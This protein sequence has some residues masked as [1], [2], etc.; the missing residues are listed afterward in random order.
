MEVYFYD[1]ETMIY[2]GHHQPARL[3]PIDKL[4]MIPA[5]STTAT[6]P[7]PM[8]G[9]AARLEANE[10]GEMEWSLRAWQ[11]FTIY[12]WDAKTTELSGT[13]I[14]TALE[15]PEVDTLGENQTFTAPPGPVPPLRYT[16]YLY[17]GIWWQQVEDYRGWWADTA[18]AEKHSIEDF[19]EI[20][21]AGWTD[22]QIPPGLK[23][24]LWDGEGWV[25]D[26]TK[27]AEEEEAR[28]EAAQSILKGVTLPQAKAWIDTNVTDLASAKVALKKMLALQWAVM[29]IAGLI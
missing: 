7:A 4:P 2:T 8:E 17:G 18:T 15:Q 21:E 16:N 22:V 10:S 24:P 27:A 13:S 9:Y 20:P 26:D 28:Q 3:D 11:D 12:E 14:I 6:P 29:K 23:Y 5:N 25:L 1:P 19:N